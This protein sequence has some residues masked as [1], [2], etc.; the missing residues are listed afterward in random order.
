MLGPRCKRC[1]DKGC[2][3]CWK[4]DYDSFRLSPPYTS[5]RYPDKDG[6]KGF[7][8]KKPRF[9]KSYYESKCRSLEGDVHSLEKQLEDVRIKYCDMVEKHSTLQHKTDNE[10][11]K[12]QDELKECRRKYSLTKDREHSYRED[13]KL[14]ETRVNNLIEGAKDKTDYKSKYE[15]AKIENDINKKEINRLTMEN[16]KLAHAKKTLEHA[17][18]VQL[19]YGM[20]AL[21]QVDD[22]TK[23]LERKNH[24]ED[25]KK[26]EEWL[27]KENERERA[28]R[29]D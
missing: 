20:Q 19:G 4:Y 16:I 17:H 14:L 18:S 7:E 8:E 13:A 9:S 24:E 10:I 27:K 2:D 21:K 1:G 28:D 11:S 5:G 26:N 6:G 23:E 3:E 15:Q 12:L 25:L 29:K 22:L